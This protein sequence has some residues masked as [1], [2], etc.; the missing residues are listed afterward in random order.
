VAGS[1][2]HVNLASFN[3][4]VLL[5]GEVRDEAT[6]AAVEREAAAIDGVSGVINELMVGGV[7]NYTSRSNDALITGKVKASFV[8]AKEL[9]ANTIKVVT[10]R[11]TVY[12]LGRVSA[13]EANQAT[14]IA[15][16][17]PGVLQVVR[18]FE[19]I[20]ESELKRPINPQPGATTSVPAP[21]TVP[22]K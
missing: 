14:E 16:G 22:A 10:E 6:K 2:G 5:T 15:R 18:A 3:R 4:K 12:L 21:G 1:D 13:R 8:D 7:S 9:Y 19:V 11:G 17:V 20:D